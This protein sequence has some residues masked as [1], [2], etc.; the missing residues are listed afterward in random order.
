MRLAGNELGD[1]EGQLVGKGQGQAMP[2]KVDVAL[3][4]DSARLLLRLIHR[5]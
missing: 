2:K 1:S 4:A 5:I 3:D